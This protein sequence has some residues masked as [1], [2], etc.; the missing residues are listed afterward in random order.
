MFSKVNFLAQKS[1]LI[2]LFNLN[3]YFLFSLASLAA[4]ANFVALE[5][6]DVDAATLNDFDSASVARNIMSFSTV[7]LIDFSTI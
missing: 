5:D 6:P 3:A 4:L 7:C 1:N 2:I